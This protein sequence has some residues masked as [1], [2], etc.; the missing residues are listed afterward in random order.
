ME[1]VGLVE[2]G[3]GSA[4]LHPNFY[5]TMVPLKDERHFFQSRGFKHEAS[6][7]LRPPLI[8]GPTRNTSLRPAL[9]PDPARKENIESS[10]ICATSRIKIPVKEVH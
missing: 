3:G 2:K 8:L 1:G 10:E 9:V 6:T 4:T 7:S 5:V